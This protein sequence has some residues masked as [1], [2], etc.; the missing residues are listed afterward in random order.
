MPGR[1]KNQ[2]AVEGQEHAAWGRATNKMS[3]A[4]GKAASG[5]GNAVG[6]A[7]AKGTGKVF[8]AALT[9]MTGF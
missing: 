3:N 5:M 9:V 1:K 7:V 4:V 8:Q 2:M 6:K